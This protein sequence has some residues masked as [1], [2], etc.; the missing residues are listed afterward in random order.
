VQSKLEKQL[1]KHI[2][3]N[4]FFT[5]KDKLLLGYSG[6]ADSTALAF[7]LKR[8]GYN[9][10]LAHCNFS[11][12]GNE[13]D[14]DQ[15][16]AEYFSEEINTPLHKIKFDT[17]AFAKNN[18]FSIEETARKLRYDWFEK[19]IQDTNI[20]YIL[21]AH[22][23]DDNV[24][25]LLIKLTA[26]TGISGL[27]GI[28]PINKNII[29]P[30]LFAS[31]TQILDYCKHHNIKFRSDSSNQDTKYTRNRFRKDVIPV[32]QEINPNLTNTL[33]RSI[34][35][36]SDIEKIYL[37]S[38]SET[39]EK[40]LSVEGNYSK[41]DI[42]CIKNT[43]APQT[44]LYEIIKPFG[45]GSADSEDIFKAFSAESGKIFISVTHKL[46]KDRTHLI[47][48]EKS[49]SKFKETSFQ[50]LEEL[51]SVGSPL[52][53]EFGKNS[54]NLQIKKDKKVAYLDLNKI[55]FPLTIRTAQ[56]GEYFYPLG[57]N[58]KKLVSRFYTDSKFNLFEKE[59]TLLLLSQNKIAWIVE[60]RI[61]NRFK[62]TEN[63]INYLKVSLD[64]TQ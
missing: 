45:F 56:T 13:S 4:L 8:L 26:G 27:T 22:H 43:E 44:Y 23:A 46:I 52:L 12:R 40:S 50:T 49:T 59:A 62:I 31:K 6:G 11:L 36:F 51:T 58:R 2:E 37:K 34:R 30:L 53:F 5:K 57:M 20:K 19:L 61:D 28:R 15:K 54:S 38:I 9:L 47:I 42:S 32:L 21:T 48:T 63:T 25:T 18:G 29:R 55:E 39:R 33:N 1:Q 16:F 64:T 24:E 41:V 3:Q 17:L 35:I 7:S 14:G 60:H 10:Q